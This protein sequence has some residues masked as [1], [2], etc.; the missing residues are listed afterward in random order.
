VYYPAPRTDVTLK[1]EG[2]RKHCARLI[3]F[4]CQPELFGEI[5][6]KQGNN[7]KNL[8]EARGEKQRQKKNSV[9]RTETSQKEQMC[10]IIRTFSSNEQN[11]SF[12]V[13]KRDGTMRK[14]FKTMRITNTIKK[15]RNG[16][17]KRRTK[18]IKTKKEFVSEF[19]TIYE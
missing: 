10:Y 17:K 18:K 12:R 8:G 15:R 13:T 9:V 14:C 11:N 16:R 4:A 7:E 1:R 5:E 2:N 3:C 19:L 6:N